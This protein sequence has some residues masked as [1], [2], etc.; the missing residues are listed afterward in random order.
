MEL[1]ELDMLLGVTSVL[2]SV[3]GSALI[4]WILEEKQ[5][6]ACFMDGVMAWRESSTVSNQSRN[7]YKK[8]L[9]YDMLHNVRVTVVSVGTK[10]GS[11]ISDMHLI[12]YRRKGIKQNI[13]AL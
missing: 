12:T 2:L 11:E 3:A 10:G 7:S 1:S 6:N 5:S 8:D 4:E 13:N 9:T